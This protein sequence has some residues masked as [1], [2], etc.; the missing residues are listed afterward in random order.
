MNVAYLRNTRLLA[1]LILAS[2]VAIK[3]VEAQPIP[4]A[5]DGTG[6]IVTPSGNRFDITGGSLSEDGANLFH[7]FEQF[8]L[9]SNQIA[10]FVSDPAIRNILGRVVGGDPSMI[11]GLI[12]VI[13]GN[14]NLY[15]INPAGIVF[16]QNA[17]LNVPGDFIATTATEIGFDRGWFQAFSSNNYSN[18]VGNPHTF[19]FDTLQPGAIVN[20]GDLAVSAGHNLALIG[21]TILNT[22]SLVAPGG[23]ITVTAVPGT[24]RVRLS[25]QGQV[26]SLEVQPRADSQGKVLPIEPQM[27]P[28]LLTNSGGEEV[29]GV[30]VNSDR[31]LILEESGTQIPTTIGTTIIAGDLDVSGDVGGEVQ[32]FGD[33]VG[34]IAANINA[35]G[36]QG[37][38]SVKIGGDYQG[39]GTLPHASH[40]YLSRDSVIR[41]DAQDVGG[42]GQVIVWADHT[43]QFYG[44]ISARGG[45][46]SGD[47]GFVEVSGKEN[48]AFDGLV[49]V[50]ATAGKNGQL[51]LDPKT[52]VIGTTGT[53]DSEI[54]DNQIL[55]GDGVGLTFQISNTAIETALNNGDVS[56]AAIK[57]IDINEDINSNSSSSLTFEAAFI[58]LNASIGLN[59]GNITFASPVILRSNQTLSTGSTV[60]GNI[61]FNRSLHGLN[62]VTPPTLTLDAGTGNVTF[63]GLVGGPLPYD[64]AVLLDAPVGYWSFEEDSGATS[65]SDV[66][67]STNMGSCST[68]TCPTAGQTGKIGSSVRFDGTDD[69]I[70]L[71][72]T[73]IVNTFTMEVWVKPETMHEIDNV[74]ADNP[75]GINYDGTSGQN[76]IFNPEQGE[77][78]WGGPPKVHLGAGASVGT[79]GVSLYDH[80]S[81]YIPAVVVSS[82]TLNDWTHIAVVYNNRTPSLYINGQ[83]VGSGVP[84]TPYTVVHPSNN[85]G[86]GVYGNFQGYADEMAIYN[87]ALSP[88][89]IQAHYNVGQGT[90]PSTP[91]GGLTITSADKVTANRGIQVNTIDLTANQISLQDVTT[92]SS[93]NA[94]SLTADEINLA[95]GVNSVTGIG[96]VQIQPRT[97][98]QDIVIADSSDTVALDLSLTDLTALQDGFNSITIGRSDG[99]G[100]IT[101]NSFSFNDPVTIAGGSTLIGP[102]VDTIYRI[103]GTDSG[104]VSGFNESLSFASIENLTGGTANDTFQLNNS[105]SISGRIDGG[106]GNDSLIGANTANTWTITAPN[107]GNINGMINFSAIENLTGGA[108]NDRFQVSNGV[109]VSGI[110]D[111]RE[112]SDEYIINLSDTGSAT[113]TIN[114]SGTTGSDRLTIKGTEATDNV[115]ITA[116]QLTRESQTV[117]YNSSL[118]N[119]EV[120]AGLGNDKITVSESLTFTGNVSLSTGLDGGDITTGDI[121]ANGGITLMSQPGIITTG[122]LNASGTTGGAIRIEAGDRIITGN[123]DTSG[124][125]GNGG[126]VILDP[127]NGILVDFINAQGGTNGSGGK[128]DITT[129]QFFQARGTFSDQNGISASISTAGG[130]GGGDIIIR[131]DGGARNTTFDVGNAQ[132]NG[133]AGAITTS[134]TNSILPPQS[135]PGSYT[136]GEIQ[137]ITQNPPPE[138]PPPPELPVLIR[139]EIVKDFQDIQ[140]SL[141]PQI[142]EQESEDLI[143]RT[144]ER[145]DIARLLDKN[146][147]PQA[148]LFIDILFSEELGSYIDQR[149]SRELKSFADIQER[150]N[151]TGE[152]TGKKPAVLYTFARAEQLDLVLVTPSGIPIHK[153]IPAAR[154]EV[155][156]KKVVEFRQDVTDP[157]KRNT[158]SYLDSAQQLY[159]WL[160]AP[161]EAELQKE[162]ISTIV[163]SM[164]AGLRAIPVA[165][166]HDGQQFLV[167]KYSLGLIPSVNL[168]DTRYQP[169]DDAQ[170][171]AMGASQFID[172]SPLPAVPLEVSI[173]ANQIWQGKSFLNAEFTLN[174]L[175]SQRQNQP[176]RII[177]LATHGEF[178]PGKPENSYIQLFDTKLQL[179]QL[180]QLGWNNP[181]VELLVLSACRTAVGDED[182]ELGFAGLAVQAGVKSALGSLWYVSDEATL[183][184]MTEFYSQLHNASIKADALRQAQITM[185]QGN[186][187]LKG[188]QLQ[189]N[190]KNLVLPPELSRLGDRELS[191]PYYWSAFT[192]IGSPW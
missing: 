37:G 28:E 20:A 61:T 50:G 183:G 143:L 89:Q 39:Q 120:D 48:L 115:E 4:S 116:T 140:P 182:A 54:S 118:E 94:V 176:F 117:N 75:I 150:L 56:I 186:V 184:L 190:G 104:E 76:Y 101:L 128:I 102:D 58:N 168:T 92:T 73:G 175:K 130:E 35:T 13:G 90:S 160:I 173:I 6:T 33:R 38:G 139:D 146:Q 177:H 152:A 66:S 113:T 17:Q 71:N 82:G 43:T 77:A 55:T 25:Q 53:N 1:G 12:Q 166:L 133:T 108:E 179:D 15:L 44:T 74:R 83:L 63:E 165:A 36:I 59:G 131:H 5:D 138:P 125:M 87:S 46:N 97:P 105:A 47:G 141:P 123:I 144:V 14:S 2:T 145:I 189:V 3:P 68:T 112:N 126:D 103:T 10:N 181:P 79:N 57:N 85:I 26:L 11:N 137:I 121:T 91:L 185:L 24:S 78:T 119:L 49:D 23:N 151:E 147:I 170:V 124:T 100:T 22:A 31:T 19:T 162:G 136:Q 110:I 134:S 40:T 187:Q 148:V 67:G 156:L 158:N 95:G 174:N 188:G 70:S 153:S 81:D 96:D 21:G 41:G 60:G 45:I 7:S 88:E 42:G 32:I 180:R 106:T 64:V 9:K 84:S 29:T 99:T 65:F 142:P 178:Q 129:Q 132:I 98:S 16:G 69:I 149:V 30:S 111:G 34:L 114:D 80:S 52:V 109:S 72:D 172:Q 161:L 93:G 122:D 62:G 159:Q 157:I 86:G 27:L 192:M 163:F 154:R 171:L 169:L 135:F 164:D 107:G 18:L 167:Q 8:G 127:E 191:H 155:L 51:F